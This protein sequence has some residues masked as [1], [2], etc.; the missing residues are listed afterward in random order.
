MTQLGTLVSE[1]G[2][3]WDTPLQEYL[4]GFAMMDKYAGEHATLRDMLEHRSGLLAYDCSVLGRLNLTDAEML[5]R[6]KYMK[7]GSSFRDRSQ[8]SNVGFFI[9]GEVASAADGTSWKDSLS[10]RIFAPLGMTRSGGIM[11]PSS[12]MGIM[13][14]AVCRMGIPSSR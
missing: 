7:S 12:W 5:E 13:W 11:P 10:T 1:G 14:R 9:A 8:Y 3:D 4:P 6:V 2:A